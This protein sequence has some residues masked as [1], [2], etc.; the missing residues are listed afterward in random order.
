MQS[1]DNCT[2]NTDR[3][4]PS[5]QVFILSEG[6]YFRNS[7]FYR[8]LNHGMKTRGLHSNEGR[9]LIELQFHVE[10]PP[11]SSAHTHVHTHVHTLF[12]LPTSAGQ[13]HSP[14]FKST[15]WIELVS[16]FHAIN[17]QTLRTLDSTDR[18]TRKVCSSEKVGGSVVR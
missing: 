17:T 13:T 11:P 1:S 3:G 10:C 7:Y 14:N 5:H 6:V 18:G 9:F 8:D 16:C 2:E 12:T 15:V 4:I